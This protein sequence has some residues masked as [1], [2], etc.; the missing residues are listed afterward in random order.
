MNQHITASEDSE[1]ITDCEGSWDSLL[2]LAA[3]PNQ[4]D[5][6]NT[7]ALFGSYALVIG[8]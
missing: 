5:H 7:N 2:L 3:E 1:L 4:E 6:T 8:L